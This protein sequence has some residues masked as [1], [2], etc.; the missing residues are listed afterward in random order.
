MQVVTIFKKMNFL[1]T[2]KKYFLFSAAILTD[3]MV[4]SQLIKEEDAK[5]K[6]L[7]KKYS[8]KMKE[9]HVRLLK[10]S[11]FLLVF[12]FPDKGAEVF[13]LSLSDPF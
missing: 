4:V 13:I 9:L 7:V 1:L 12:S 2:K 8:H 11:I 3:P 5:V 10:D 6:E